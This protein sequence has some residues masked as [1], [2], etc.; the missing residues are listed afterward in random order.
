MYVYCRISDDNT[1]TIPVRSELGY[2]STAHRL[3]PFLEFSASL[4][5]DMLCFIRPDNGD[6]DEADDGNR[7]KTAARLAYPPTH[8]PTEGRLGSPPA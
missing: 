1:Y 2:L 3:S 8:R 4:P 5:P 7:R 6:D